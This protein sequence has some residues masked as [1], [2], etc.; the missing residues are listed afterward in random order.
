MLS[1]KEKYLATGEF[2]KLIARLV[3]LGNHQ[4]K[5]L[6]KKEDI[7][8]PTVNLLLLFAIVSQAHK[9]GQAVK[10]VDITGAYFKTPIGDKEVIMKI[11]RLH[12]IFLTQIDTSVEPYLDDKGELVVMLNKALYGCIQSAL[13]W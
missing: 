7:N 9:E 2:E 12:Q 1:L 8:S 13:Q 10:T 5:S 4:D 11:D 3:A 6:F